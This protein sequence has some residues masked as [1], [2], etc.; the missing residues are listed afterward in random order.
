MSFAATQL[1]LDWASNHVDEVTAG[2]A[3]VTVSFTGGSTS[4]WTRLVENVQRLSGTAEHG[5][6]WLQLIGAHRDPHQQTLEIGVRKAHLFGSHLKS[7]LLT[8]VA[9]ANA[10]SAPD[11]WRRF[12]PEPPL[13]TSF[14]PALVRY[15]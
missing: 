15:P 8:A 1:R 10:W 14:S 3:I 2:L 9:E 4:S 12:D 6:S 5:P 11:V 7:N 13:S